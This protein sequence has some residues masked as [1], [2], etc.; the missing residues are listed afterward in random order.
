MGSLSPLSAGGWVKAEMKTDKGPS[1]S[2]LRFGISPVDKIDHSARAAIKCS[3]TPYSRVGSAI[4]DNR[5]W[6]AFCCGVPLNVVG[7]RN[8]CCLACGAS[9]F[10]MSAQAIASW[11]SAVGWK[12]EAGSQILRCA[13]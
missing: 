9:M 5:R 12:Q 11:V 13:T 3:A 1:N 8:L 4:C 6:T 2:L 10:C 7:S